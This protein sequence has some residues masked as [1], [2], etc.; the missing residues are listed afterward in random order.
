MGTTSAMGAKPL[1]T[2]CAIVFASAFAGAVAAQDRP[3]RLLRGI[4]AVDVVVENVSRDAT[5]CGVKSAAL[6][7]TLRVALQVSPIRQDFDAA[8]Y[9]Y[10][11]GLFLASETQCLYTLSLELR[12]PVSIEE[13]GSHGVA[14]IWRTGFIEATGLGQAP[15]RIRGAIESMADELVG[16]WTRANR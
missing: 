11:R 6:E 8:A 16:E 7:S 2:A 4:D 9:V 15:V 12:S 1:R 5:R 13:T 14:S 3:A 10:L